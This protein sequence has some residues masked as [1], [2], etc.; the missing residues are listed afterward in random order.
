MKRLWQGCLALA[1]GLGAGHAGAEEIVWKAVP[2]TAPAPQAAA[3]MP[4]ITLGAPRPLPAAGVQAV[5]YETNT[6]ATPSYVARGQ[7]PDP[8]LPGPPGPVPGGP[9]LPPGGPGFQP[10]PPPPYPPPGF[11]VPGSNDE[12][13]LCG[14]TVANSGGGGFFDKSKEAIGGIPGAIGGALG[15]GGNRCPLQSDHA[16]DSF[17]SPVSDPFLM[18]DPRSLTEIKPLF[19]YEHVPSSNPNFQGGSAYFYGVNGS[20]AITDRLSIVIDKLGLV[21]LRPHTT[22]KGIGDETGFAETMLG[23]QYTFIRCENSGTLLAGGLTFDI[24]WGS[25]RVFQNT[26]DLSLI[27]YVSFAQNFLKTC[28]GSFNFMNTTGYSFATDNQ[29]NDFFYSDF[30]LD[31]DVANLHKI[32][33]M[34]ELNWMHYTTNGHPPTF[35]GFNGG[36]LINFGNGGVAGQNDVTVALGAR[37]KFA[38]WFQIGAAVE[39]PVYNRHEGIEDYRLQLDLI[40]RY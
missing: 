18:H 35:Y 16:F 27:P 29:R 8:F 3:E 39:L 4:A 33:P 10:P 22:T 14:V 7:N 30:H 26:G 1:L 28:Y 34:V 19:I 21:T 32:Y 37:Y 25:N 13:L 5:S 38:E 20:V 6:S 2:E 36:D 40:F 11:I 12:K 31:F 17:A 15:G 23:P 9:M 24:P